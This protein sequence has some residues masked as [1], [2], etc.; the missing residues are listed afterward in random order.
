MCKAQE[1][2]KKKKKTP[3]QPG[4]TQSIAFM[5]PFTDQQEKDYHLFLNKTYC[6]HVKA[7]EAFSSYNSK[8]RKSGFNVSCQLHCIFYKVLIGSLKI[9][10]L[11]QQKNK[12][13]SAHQTF[14]QQPQLRAKDN[15][16]TFN[17]NINLF[18]DSFYLVQTQIPPP[19][20][21]VFTNAFF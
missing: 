2:K 19:P 1:K 6:P 12:N 20:H 14:I 21:L 10:T 17:A 13:F 15:P 8:R 3:N 9:S 16:N 11:T 7:R 18:E 4:T 5:F